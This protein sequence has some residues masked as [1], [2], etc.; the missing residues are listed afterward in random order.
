MGRLQAWASTLFN[1]L[2]VYGFVLL[3]GWTSDLLKGDALFTWSERD[4][5]LATPA[6]LQALLVML[7]LSLALGYWLYRRRATFL[8]VRV[9]A[10]RDQ[11]AMRPHAAVVLSVSNSAWRFDLASQSLVVRDPDAA[12]S[13]HACPPSVR[14]LLALLAGLNPRW[15]WEMLLRGLLP[16]AD[17]LRCVVLI[18]S[19]D[20]HAVIGECRDLVRHYFPRARVSVLGPLDFEDIDALLA[21]YERAARECEVPLKDLIIDVTGGSK[22]VSIAAALFTLRHPQ[23]EFQYVSSAGDK[24]PISFNVVSQQALG[25]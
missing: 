5:R 3:Q 11:A 8:P 13:M 21:A 14:E 1:V 4:I 18:A 24:Q 20:S 2:L 19:R 12:P 23:V 10:R 9:L 7:G 25:E 6:G 16:H 22:L 17:R 15:S